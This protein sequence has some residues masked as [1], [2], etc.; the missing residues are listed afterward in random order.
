MAA[1]EQWTGRLGFVLASVGA[2]VGLGNL[3][4]FPTTAAAEGGGAFVLMYVVLCLAIGVPGVMAELALGRRTGQSPVGAFAALKPGTAW[5][6]VGALGV[7]TGA[8]ILSYYSVIAGWVMAYTVQ[9]ARGTLL[10]G[11]AADLAAAFDA[12][13]SHPWQPLVWHLVFMSVTAL[14]VIGGIRD[15][16][17]RCSKLLMPIL[18]LLL[19]AVAVRVLTLPGAREGLVWFLRPDWGALSWRTVLQ[20]LGQVFFSAS[21]GMGA[22]ITYGSYLSR[23]EDIPRSAVTIVG[24]DAGIALLAGMAIIPGLFALGLPMESGPGLLFVVLPGVFM[25]MPA[26]AFFA[27][28][29]FLMVVIAALTSSISL[30]EVTVSFVVDRLGIGR[31]TATLAAACVVA[32]AGVPSALAAGALAGVRWLAM[33]VLSLAD[34][35]ASNLFLP[36]GGLLTALFVAWVWGARP[37]AEEL[38]LGAARFA[39]AGLWTAA[40]RWAVPAAIAV[41]LAAGLIGGR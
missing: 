33:D 21:L 1:R 9:A 30:L 7:F 12:L 14:V 3:W 25:Q 37:A 4:R 17:E 27:L 11:G 16:I 38:H 28:L 19:L 31:R 13:I 39:T 15:G 5:W 8:L 22:M 32:L 24:A 29:F 36:L 41:V 23:R 35:L 26:G 18:L 40:M 2:A 20:A 34:F 6:V 10:S